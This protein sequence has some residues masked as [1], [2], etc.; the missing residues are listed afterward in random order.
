MRISAQYFSENGNP[1]IN[2]QFS[3]ITKSLYKATIDAQII[4]GLNQS[5][6]ANNFSVLSRSNKRMVVG[7]L[8]KIE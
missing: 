1:V 5:L 3:L 7:V 8:G 4:T 2:G 6:F